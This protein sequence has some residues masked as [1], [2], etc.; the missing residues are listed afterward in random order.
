MAVPHTNTT[1][2]IYRF[3]NSPPAA[4]DVAGVRCYLAPLGES[5]LTTHNYTHALL[6]PPDTDIRD[7]Y[8][9]STFEGSG[10]DRV[11]VPDRNGTLFKVVLVRRKGRGT[12]VDHK[13]VLVTRDDGV[14]VP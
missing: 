10:G 8:L 3:G 5:T 12:A 11:Y 9:P 14:N 4:P 7:S 2:D 6:V 13:Y 1:C